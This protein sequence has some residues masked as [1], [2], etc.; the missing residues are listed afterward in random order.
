MIDYVDPIPPVIQ[1]Y[2]SR[3]DV[4]VQGNMLMPET[5]LPVLLVKNAGSNGRSTRLQLLARSDNDIEAMQTLIHAMNLLERDCRLIQGLQIEDCHRD[6]GPFPDTD[7]DSK[8]PEAW[9]YM[10]LYHLES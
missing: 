3:V 1:F 2:Q 8:K 4:N 9:C 5:P 6:S 7:D 10:L